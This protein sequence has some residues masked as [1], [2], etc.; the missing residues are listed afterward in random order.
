M[1]KAS[2]LY[3]LSRR[4]LLLLELFNRMDDDEQKQKLTGFIDYLMGR[5]ILSEDES[6]EYLKEIKG[7][8]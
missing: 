6:F 5:G 3:E 2:D 8:D 1:K 4:E 7:K